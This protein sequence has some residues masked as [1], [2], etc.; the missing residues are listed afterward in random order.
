MLQTLINILTESLH[1]TNLLI[2]FGL[3]SVKLIGQ[4]LLSQM[5]II[6]N[7]CKMQINSLEVSKF[8]LHLVSFLFKYSNLSFS[9][10]NVSLEFLDLVVEH[11]FELLKLLRLPTKFMNLA[12]FVLDGVITLFHLNTLTCDSLLQSIGLLVELLQLTIFPDN[13]VVLELF[14]LILLLEHIKCKSEVSLGFHTIIDDFTQL[15]FVLVPQLVNAIPSIILD[16]LSFISMSL[17]HP[18]DFLVQLLSHVVLLIRL[19]SLIL[20]H[21]FDDLSVVK[22]ELV[23]SLFESP[24]VLISLVLELLKP[25]LISGFL[26]IVL[27]LTPLL[28]K[29]VLLVHHL[30]LFSLFPFDFLLLGEQTGVSLLVLLI[31]LLMLLLQVEDLLSFLLNLLLVLLLSV[32]V[33]HSNV[34]LQS[35]DL[36]L[37]LNP[38]LLGKQD[39]V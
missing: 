18:V 31:L 30:E 39:L 33:P 34:L 26:L 35:L 6:D 29:F 19:H 37:Q 11:E 4:T 7:K 38:L 23:E 24:S 12:V 14:F 27:L 1:I 2:Q 32:G 28:V 3:K 22:G 17:H 20:L 16:G 5:K 15:F 36:V 25:C 10:T 8:L 21:L 13:I 9:G